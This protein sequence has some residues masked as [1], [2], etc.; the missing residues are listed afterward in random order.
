MINADKILILGFAREGQSTYHFLR[1]KYPGLLIGIADAKTPATIPDDPNTKTY[2][3]PGYLS[4]VTDFPLVYKTPGIS[5]HKPEIVAAKNSGVIFTSHMQLFMDV[6]P[7]PN[8]IGVSGTKGKST[9]AS[10]IHEVLEA[11]GIPTVLV[12]NIGKPALDFLP[13]ITSATWVV[14]ELSS[15]QLMDLKVSPHIAVLQ[16]I[17]P[18]HLDYHS[19]F[20]EYVDA[21][22]NIGRFQT[23][24]DHIVFN[25]DSL[26]CTEASKIS[27]A[28][29][30]PFSLVN[31]DSK[32]ETRL[33]GNHNKLNIL[34][35]L[36]ISEI[37][38]L[39]MS[40][41][42]QAIKN[43]QPLDTRLQEVGSVNG[44]RFFEDTLATIPEATIAAID[45]LHPK[46]TTLIAGGHERKQNY[47]NLA[48][49]ILESGIKTLIVF[50]STGPRIWDE[51]TS[52]EANPNI[53]YHYTESMPDAVRIAL[54]QTAS[55]E[56]C[57][58]SP[59]APSFTLFKDYR[60]EG[61]Q[62][63]NAIKDLS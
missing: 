4:A 59:A 40:K 53:S 1:S 47:L 12:G 36:K 30:H 56:I 3:G 48:K 57:L 46:V 42:L 2:F 21:K 9:T 44:I 22:T 17:F 15:Y 26:V 8:I 58:L 55:G 14:C 13:E 50:P 39:S 29:K 23:P 5:P 10:L 32:I 31:F 16:N 25:A 45:A 24:D 35:S 38:H 27:P 52:L 43:F 60:D 19:N 49:K 33:I 37:L 51:V 6:C 11:N 34:P 7:S 18:D 28:Q 54:D 63:R 62:Y 41:T 20:A 61:Q